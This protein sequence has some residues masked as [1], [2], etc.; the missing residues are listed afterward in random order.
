ME[1]L[2]PGEKLRELRLRALL[3]E[4]DSLKRELIQKFRHQLQM[5]YIIIMAIGS[6]FGYILT[7]KAY[8][9]FLIIPLVGAAFGFRYIW[10]Q[11]IINRI[12]DYLRTL[13][14]DLIPSVIG[15]RKREAP[16]VSRQLWI[17][18]EL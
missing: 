13:E 5:Y 15:R 6:L 4:Y 18:R 14:S 12:G 1:N 2:P 3:T 8:D 17:I 11:Y 7:K 9:V 16:L 10:E